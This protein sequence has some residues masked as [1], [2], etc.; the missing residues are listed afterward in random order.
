MLDVNN[1]DNLFMRKVFKKNERKKVIYP[2]M[3]Q[4][5][6]RE[7]GSELLMGSGSKMV[8]NRIQLPSKEEKQSNINL[9]WTKPVAGLWW[10]LSQFT[11]FDFN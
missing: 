10:H 8:N 9:S 4:K 2:I 6:E 3:C 7:D 5:P 1:I 11:W